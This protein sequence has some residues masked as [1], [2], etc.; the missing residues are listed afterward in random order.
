MLKRTLGWIL[1]GL[2]L[3]S[4]SA[5]AGGRAVTVYP[6]YVEGLAAI[7]LELRIDDVVVAKLEAKVSDSAPEPTMKVPLAAGFHRYAVSGEARLTDGRR[8]QLG[9]RGFVAQSEFLTAR[10]EAK[11]AQREPLAVVEALLRELRALPEAPALPRLER[12]AR[13]PIVPALEAVERAH[14]IAL[15]STCAALLE[16][17]GPFVYVSRGDDGEEPRAALYAPDRWLSV[18][19]WR[20][21]IRRA[22]VEP[23]DTPK[24][25]K[26]MAEV[27][28]DI[29]LGHTFDTVWTLRAG[30][31]PR[32][33]DGSAS[34]SGEFLYEN[35]PAEDLWVEGTDTHA[36]Y[37]GDREARCGDRTQLLVDNY[38]AAFVAGF[39]DV[40]ALS[41]DGTLRL[42]QD[43]E[44][45]TAGMLA[46]SFG[47]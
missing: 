38:S 43:F 41:Q 31:H 9:G 3:A 44:R 16:R 29:V 25:R 35:D 19:E 5:E 15:P 13:V 39:G 22:P 28:S 26:R 30:T 47:E 1:G 27:A 18:P 46:L 23:G 7:R 37:F 8:L 42:Q 14:G 11:E 40:L 32:C 17:F 6:P 10:L 45:T 24:A 21:Q 20:R 36:G 34:L 2:G 4:S 33:P 12:S